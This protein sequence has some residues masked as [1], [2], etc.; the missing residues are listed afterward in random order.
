MSS[1][2]LTWL[3]CLVSFWTWVNKNWLELI[4]GKWL[5][6]IKIE[7]SWLDLTWTKLDFWTQVNK[8]WLELTWLDLEKMF[9]W[10]VFEQLFETPVDL[11]KNVS[12]QILENDSTQKKLTR[13]DLTG[14]KCFVK[15]CLDSIFEKS[16]FYLMIDLSRS[17]IF[18]GK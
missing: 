5:N 17:R 6:S 1:P 16:W 13:L 2:D 11:E 14:Q 3:M 8:N 9:F 18:F 15:I 7:S 10:S 4:F 12:S